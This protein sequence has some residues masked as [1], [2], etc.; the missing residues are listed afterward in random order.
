MGGDPKVYMS[1]IAVYVE[2]T[3]ADDAVET[4]IMNH[5]AVFQGIQPY[6]HSLNQHQERLQTV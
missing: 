4:T 6:T 5:V 3:K 2:M 1:N